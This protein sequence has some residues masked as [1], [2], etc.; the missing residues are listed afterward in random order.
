[1]LRIRK[2]QQAGNTVFLLSGRIK[3]EDI[4]EI[5]ELLKTE[6][7]LASVILDLQ[8][9]R[10][11]HRDA[12]RFLASCETQGVRLKNCPAFVREW[13]LTGGDHESRAFAI[14]R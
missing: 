14:G 11:V 1:M 2:F 12:V 13:I 6:D 8:E 4:S 5:I 3:A 7:S 9:V 10:L